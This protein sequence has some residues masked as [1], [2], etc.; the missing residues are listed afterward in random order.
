MRHFYYLVMAV[1]CLVLTGCEKRIMEGSDEDNVLL[2]LSLYEQESFG[3]RSVQDISQWCSRVNV[4]FFKDGAKVK[5][6]SQERSFTSFGNVPVQ[7]EAGTYQVVVM[8]HSCSGSA[9]ISTE[10]HVTFPDNMVTDTFYYYGTLSVTGDAQQFELVLQRCVAMFRLKVLDDF[11]SNAARIRF[12]YTGGSST[13]S[14][15]AGYGSVNSRQSVMQ[16]IESGQKVFEVYTLPWSETGTLKMAI[17]VYDSGNNI[18]RELP[19]EDVPVT[20]N[21][22]TSY[23][24]AL[25]GG[26]VDPTGGD[27]DT[28]SNGGMH[29]T[30]DGEWSG[31]V[32]QTF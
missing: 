24:G 23:S 20:R 4:A 2:R 26:P 12:Y 28:S 32:N 15:K 29:L 9:T 31:T 18:L 14:P 25:F 8:A 21:K 7:L 6:V 27:P 1:V 13:F 5:T 16:V 30:A 19:L 22:I 10:D 17:T 3:T 11:P